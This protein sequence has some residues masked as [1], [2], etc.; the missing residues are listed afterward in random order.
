M[1]RKKCSATSGVLRRKVMGYGH[2]DVVLTIV[3][4]ALTLTS[5]GTS[6]QLGAEPDSAT[7]GETPALRPAAAAGSQLR[8]KPDRAGAYNILHLFTWA[9]Y[10]TGKLVFDAANIWVANSGGGGGHTVTKLRAS[11]GARLGAFRVGTNPFGVAFDGADIWAPN[12]SDN[13]VTKL[14]A[15]DGATLGTFAVGRGPFGV[16]FDGANIWV[17]NANSNTVSK[18]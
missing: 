4:A 15:S 17:T 6:S 8:V 12:Y 3:L 10:P 7:A 14:R 5:D 13:S 11:D 18:L 1:H 9:Q 2:W 16:A